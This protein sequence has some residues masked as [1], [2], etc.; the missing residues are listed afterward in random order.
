MLSTCPALEMT[1]HPGLFPPSWLVCTAW[2]AR[3]ATSAP[4]LEAED[5]VHTQQG[6]SSPVIVQSWT[7]EEQSDM[8]STSP[9][10][11]THVR[12][13]TYSYTRVYLL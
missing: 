3:S 11:P 10:P 1:S 6:P 12:E 8:L 2:V 13:C 9:P 7:S 5:P 4:G